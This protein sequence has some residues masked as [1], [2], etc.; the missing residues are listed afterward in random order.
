MLAQ[1]KTDPKKRPDYNCSID[2]SQSRNDCVDIGNP[3]PE[4]SADEKKGD[5][6]AV[7]KLKAKAEKE[8][9]G[10]LASIK[11]FGVRAQLKPLCPHPMIPGVDKVPECDPIA[12]L[13]CPTGEKGDSECNNMRS[14][15]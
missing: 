10:A 4:A 13:Y 12:P 6:G 2:G 1:H 9:E 11:D 14:L 7:E 8:S 5:E 15:A 3:I